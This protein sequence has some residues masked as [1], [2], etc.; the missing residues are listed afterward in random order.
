MDSDVY[1]LFFFLYY[2]YVSGH[3]E[4]MINGGHS[5]L[6]VL[7][8]GS[9]AGFV[10]L[11]GFLLRRML[12]YGLEKEQNDRGVMEARRGDN[13]PA[14]RSFDKTCSGVV[15]VNYGL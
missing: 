15:Y 14:A 1:S 7:V 8:L 2:S 11:P 12:Q 10:I 4:D 9:F 6:F 5:Y 13:T 3:V